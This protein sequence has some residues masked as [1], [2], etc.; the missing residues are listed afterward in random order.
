MSDSAS[1]MSSVS[2]GDDSSNYSNNTEIITRKEN[3]SESVISSIKQINLENIQDTWPLSTNHLCWWCT[4]EVDGRPIFLPLEKDKNG[5]Y[6]CIGNFCSFSC[7]KSYIY[8]E[9][10]D[11]SYDESLACDMYHS[12]TAKMNWHQISCAPKKVQMK[13][14][15]GELTIKEYKKIT[16]NHTDTFISVENIPHIKIKNN[17]GQVSNLNN[18]F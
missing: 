8:Y 3:D 4:L 17:L 6:Q 18:Y 11:E 16:T 2:S 9:I 12:L 15:G 7:M 5:V 10:N 13:I 14:Y 1:S